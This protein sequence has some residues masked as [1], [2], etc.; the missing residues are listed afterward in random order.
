MRGVTRPVTFR[1]TA[2]KT[3][4]NALVRAEGTVTTSAFGVAR[5]SNLGTTLND[6]VRVTATDLLVG[7]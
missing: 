2:E 4:D 5:I 1:A 7:P 3:G 6:E